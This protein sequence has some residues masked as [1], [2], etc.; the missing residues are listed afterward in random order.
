MVPKNTN[1]HRKV[2]KCVPLP[3]KKTLLK[4]EIISLSEKKEIIK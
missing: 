1:N 3:F 4:K 2:Y